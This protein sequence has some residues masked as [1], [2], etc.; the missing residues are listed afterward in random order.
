MSIMK[1]CSDRNVRKDFFVARNKFATEEAFDNRPLILS[2]LEKRDQKS[3]LL[4]YKN[5]AEL[6]L[7]FKMAD[8][9]EQILEIFEDISS[10]A[11]QKARK[12][13]EELEQY[14]SLD[15]LRAYDLSYYARKLKQEKYALDEKELKKYFVFEN[16]QKGMFEIV[17]KLTGLDIQK[18]H[19]DTYDE[20]VSVYEVSKEGKFLSYFFTDY[21]YRPLK[22]NGAWANILKEKF[23]GNKKIVVNVANFQKSTD[24]QTL[25]TLGDVET[26]FHEF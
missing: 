1:Y 3:Q 9:P 10:K 22:R 18:I 14:F 15:E 7:H 4:G 2:I 17:Q 5:Y 13:N 8:T 23:A 6:S 12:E 20:N 21:F 11:Q 24:E 26:M 25:L 19:V 16:V